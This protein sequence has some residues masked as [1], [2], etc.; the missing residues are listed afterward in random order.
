MAEPYVITPPG[1][2]P[3]EPAAVAP[4]P[5]ITTPLEAPTGVPAAP[6][7][8]S[9]YTITPPAGGPGVLG[10]ARNALPIVEQTHTDPQ[11]SLWRQM[12][13]IGGSGLSAGID[14]LKNYVIPYTPPALAWTAIKA[15]W[16]ALAAIDRTGVKF[17]EDHIAGEAGYDKMWAEWAKNNP[18]FAGTN[19][20]PV[21]ASEVTRFVLDPMNLLFITGPVAKGGKILDALGSATAKLAA[22][23]GM[24]ET[25]ARV[26]GQLVKAAHEGKL[27]VSGNSIVKAWQWMDKEVMPLF[28]AFHGMPPEIKAAFKA[29]EGRTQKALLDGTKV[30]NDYA[31]IN[32][33]DQ[34]LL[35]AAIREVPDSASVGI[36]TIQTDEI[37]DRFIVEMQQ[38]DRD[39]K[40][41]AQAGKLPEHLREDFQKM[42]EVRDKTSME[43]IN[44]GVLEGVIANYLR[45]LYKPEQASQV[46]EA[47][48]RQLSPRGSGAVRGSLFNKVFH[49]P[50]AAAEAGFKPI[51]SATHLLAAHQLEIDIAKSEIQLYRDVVRAGEGWTR[52]APQAMGA[53]APAGEFLSRETQWQPITRW[54]NSMVAE[55]QGMKMLEVHPQ[56]ASVMDTMMMYHYGE[57]RAGAVLKVIDAIEGGEKRWLF[58]NPLFHSKNIGASAY[59]GAGARFFNPSH[60]KQWNRVLED[61]RN[62]GPL[63]Q[64]FLKHENWGTSTANQMRDFVSEIAKGVEDVPKSWLDPR[65]AYGRLRDFSD[66]MLWDVGDRGTRLGLFEHFWKERGLEPKDAARLANLFI[67]NYSTKLFSPVDKFLQRMLFTYSWQK[68][69]AALFTHM[70]KSWIPNLIENPIERQIMR[71]ATVRWAATQSIMPHIARAFQHR[72]DATLLD[73]AL[74]WGEQHGQVRD[75]KLWIRPTGFYND[76]ADFA[77]DPPGYLTGRQD[78]LVRAFQSLGKAKLDAIASGQSMMSAMDW[79]NL[80]RPYIPTSIYQ[81]IIS[82]R[83]WFSRIPPAVG[84]PVGTTPPDSENPRVQAHEALM[85]GETATFMHILHQG[86]MK[87]DDFTKGLDPELV[88][89]LNRMRHLFG[90]Q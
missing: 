70:A 83:S 80:M 16:N 35:S 28:N 64:E 34:A 47:L 51:T 89:K 48:M 52:I 57:G 77:K 14:I 43:G 41:A 32:P 45:G 66:H 79:N 30:L 88:R 44:H 24:D 75:R 20:N 8:P 59:L 72:A 29:H 38:A 31:H 13:Q 26:A 27:G 40:L 67:N 63:T 86:H 50:E 39:A 71:E 87:L 5:G 62:G 60:Y 76:V 49:T 10:A 73:G 85:R 56:L 46:M 6:S 17:V 21:L 15:G 78:P 3:Q 84:F 1:G 18:Q 23:T 9:P 82:D 90:V 7:A 55:N 12:Y 19:F 37:G 81:S 61:A 42:V 74:E 68:G 53:H 11:S 69:R 33:H 22:G 4:I 36:R 58:L 65:T 2:T 25:L 54:M